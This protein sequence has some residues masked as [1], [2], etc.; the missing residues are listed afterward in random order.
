LIV[1]AAW[2]HDQPTFSNRKRR[3]NDPGKA[4]YQ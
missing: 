1:R 3:N 4:D 2:G